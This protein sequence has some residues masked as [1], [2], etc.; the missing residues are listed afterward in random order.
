M[1]GM[2]ARF[3]L[4][5]LAAGLGLLVINQGAMAQ[6]LQQPVYRVTNAADAAANPATAE[7]D[8]FDLTQREGEHP[9]APSHRLAHRVLQYI[10]TE[11]KD[12]SCIFIK[13]ERVDGKLTEVNYIDMQVLHDPF[14]VHME[15]IKPNAG[16]ECL[17]VEG[18]NDNKLL[19]RA[20]GWRGRVTGVL[21]LDPNGSLAMDGNRHPITKAGMRNLTN[22]IIHITEND[23]KYGECE[24]KVY[25][26][27]K[28]G[29]R[30][31]I[32]IEVI[33]PKPRKEF[34]FHKA[35]LH[36]DRE[37]KLPVRFEEYDWPKTEGAQPELIGQYLYT[38]L[39]LNN[40]YQASD[41]SKSNPEYFK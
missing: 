7:A 25:P 33:H 5:L 24:V 10:D 2:T 4:S 8:F 28:N 37:L 6:Q 20:H 41:F 19:A 15:F 39:K 18:H 23:M 36:I 26:D 3:R 11:V 9:L 1:N 21:S 22:E 17:Y 40:G 35:H 13:R 29:D 16:Q 27:A 30:P 12:Y 38:E 32:L 34:K 14:S 31:T